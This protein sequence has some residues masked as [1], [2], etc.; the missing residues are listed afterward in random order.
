[1][2]SVSFINKRSEFF[3]LHNWIL[4]VERHLWVPFT[5]YK[6]HRSLPRIFVEIFVC[7]RVLFRNLNQLGTKFLWNLRSK[8]KIVNM[9]G[10]YYAFCQN[11]WVPLYLSKDWW[12]QLHPQT[13]SSKGPVTIWIWRWNFPFYTEMLIPVWREIGMGKIPHSSLMV[14]SQFST[15]GLAVV[16]N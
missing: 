9:G 12:V 16:M 6:N 11:K 3:L 7:Y 8:I 2:Q 15:L 4:N 14:H 13:C 10:Y 5:D 1:M